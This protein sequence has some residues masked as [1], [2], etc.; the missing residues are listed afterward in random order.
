M[1]QCEIGEILLNNLPKIAD[2][3]PYCEKHNLNI[4]CITCEGHFCLEVYAKIVNSMLRLEKF[5]WICIQFSLSSHD[6]ELGN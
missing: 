6:Y 5:S 1:Y 3:F 4:F 2:K